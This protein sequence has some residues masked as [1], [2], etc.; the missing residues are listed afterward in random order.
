VHTR[1]WMVLALASLSCGASSEGPPPAPETLLAVGADF[2]GFHGWQSFTPTE[3]FLGND[4]LAGPRT[5]YVNR[6]PSPSATEFPVG[7][8]FVKESGGG[9]VLSRHVFAMV[10]RGGGFNA[11]GAVNWEWFELKNTADD[12]PILDWRGL[13]PQTGDAYGSDATGGCNGCHS[14]EKW[15]YVWSAQEFELLGRE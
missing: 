13:G 1:V 6:L 3:S 12:R 8:I 7:T 4:H 14:G 5:I 10:K 15:D 2:A 9:D 11:K